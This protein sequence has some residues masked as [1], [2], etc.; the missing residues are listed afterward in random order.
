M[1]RSAAASRAFC[2]RR[3]SPLCLGRSQRVVDGVALLVDDVVE[4]AGDLVVHAAEVVTVEPLLALRAELL[5]QLADPC[6][7]LAVAVAH[8]LLHHPPQGGVDVAVVQ[9]LVGEL[10]EERVGVEVEPALR[11][12]PPRV[13]ELLRHDRNV[14][15]RSSKAHAA[16]GSVGR[17]IRRMRVP[18][19]FVFVDLSGFTNYTAAFGDD[20]AGRILSTFRAIVREVASERGVRIAKWLG[21]GCMVGRRRADR[22]DHVHARARA[23]RHR[24]VRTAH[25]ARRHR[26]RAR[27][28]VRGRRLHRLGRQHGGPAVRRRPAVRGADADHAPRSAARGRHGRPVRRDRA[29]RLP[30]RDRRRRASRACPCSHRP[31]TPAS[32]GPAARSPDSVA[33]RPS[34]ASPS[35]PRRRSVPLHRAISATARTTASSPDGPTTSTPSP[36]SACAPCGCRSTGR[37]CSHDRR[38]STA[39]GSSGTARCS[40]PRSA[41]AWSRG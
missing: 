3:S 23:P 24:R 35:P 19:T 15:L 7:P 13:G 26:Q 38:S 16:V 6:Q 20:A 32:S 14:A 11:A 2:S 39:S 17:I 12:I 28:A 34:E 22:R 21:D 25:A 8:A 1:L 40:R 9:Q 37:G 36:T 33:D 30:R 31:T 5:E 29:A 10:V 27:V 41:S 4:L 18:R